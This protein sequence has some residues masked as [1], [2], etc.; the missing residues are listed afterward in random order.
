MQTLCH[1]DPATV[2]NLSEP[3]RPSSVDLATGLGLSLPERRVLRRVTELPRP[4]HAMLG[5][6]PTIDKKR[7]ARRPPIGPIYRLGQQARPGTLRIPWYHMLRLA[8]YAI[9]FIALLVIG[10]LYISI[11]PESEDEAVSKIEMLGG[12]A[13]G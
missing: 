13:S 4:T 5:Y 12:E 11:G 1:L 3:E 2:F 10:L 6:R 9:P 7:R 8:K